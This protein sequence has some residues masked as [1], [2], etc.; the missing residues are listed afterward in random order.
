MSSA[1]GNDSEAAV[2]NRD[3]LREAARTQIPRRTRVA[4]AIISE[5]G[6]YPLDILLKCYLREDEDGRKNGDKRLLELAERVRHGELTP[7]KI[8]GE[9]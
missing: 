9:N 4:M 1:R 7:V 5:H 8:T 2:V 3:Q 6:N